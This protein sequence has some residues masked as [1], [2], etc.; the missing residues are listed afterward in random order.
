MLLGQHF[1]TG[2][3]VSG[4][5]SRAAFWRRFGRHFE[6]G[7]R[8]VAGLDLMACRAPLKTYTICE[9]PERVCDS[10]LVGL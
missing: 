5:R 8:D 3:A 10:R 7:F 1:E 4:D 9:T 2:G 6:T